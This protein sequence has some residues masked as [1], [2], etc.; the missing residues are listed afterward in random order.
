MPVDQTDLI[1]F[2]SANMPEN[3]TDPSGGAI[4]TTGIV[5]FTDITQGQT[6]TIEALSDNAGD[7]MNLTVWGRTAGGEIVSETKALNGTTFISFSTLGTIE[8]FMKA[9]LASAATGTV[10]IRRTT[11]AAQITKIG[12]GI[13]TGLT[14]VR[15]LFYNAAS[16]SGQ[17]VRYEKFFFKNTDGTS[18]LLGANVTLTAD[19]ASSVRIASE[20]AVNDTNSA[21][22]RETAPTGNQAWVDDSTAQNLP[23]DGN[24]DA[25]EAIGVWVEMTRAAD[26]AAV[27]STFTVQ[28]SG[29]TT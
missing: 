3:D 22:N 18:S 12:N 4:D 1:A 19:P 29:T 17:T 2:V 10:T 28:I 11:G 23:G 20:D 13:A 27:K 6:D 15:R 9:S 26:A 21:T 24:L 14:H 5:E 25:G 16:E 8:R 7:T